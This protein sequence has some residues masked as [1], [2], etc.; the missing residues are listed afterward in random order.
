MNVGDIIEAAMWV[1][2]DESPDLRRRYEKD[3][4]EAIYETCA[5]ERFLCGP[6]TWAEKLPED[7][8]SPPVPDNLQGQRVRLLVAEADIVGLMPET[9]PDSFIA[10][11]E[12]DDLKRLR[13]I[14]RAV[15]VKQFKKL[16]TDAECDEVIEA[17]GPDAAIDAL[18]NGASVH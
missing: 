13:G 15:H 16:I 9:N 10:N 12:L 1:T 17:L 11:L 5:T 3:V 6:I 8:R 14:T 7:E 18:R 2:G 4:T